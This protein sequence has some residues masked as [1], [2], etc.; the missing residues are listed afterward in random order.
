MVLTNLIISFSDN[1]FSSK[2]DINMR[3]PSAGT[4]NSMSPNLVVAT[5]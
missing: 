2:N 4:G 3:I 5:Q 1:P